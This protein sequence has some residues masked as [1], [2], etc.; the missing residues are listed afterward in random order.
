M[1]INVSGW[2]V[3]LVIYCC[4]INV[5]QNLVAEHDRWN[6]LSSGSV[7]RVRLYLGLQLGDLLGSLSDDS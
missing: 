2:E 6:S 4:V 3:V 1:T 5:S 7:T